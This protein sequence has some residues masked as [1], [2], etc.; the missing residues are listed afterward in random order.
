MPYI[1]LGELELHNRASHP[2]QRQFY[3]EAGI[4]TA[5]FMG[6]RNGEIELGSSNVVQLNMQMEMRTF[7]PEDFSRQLS[8]SA[9]AGDQLPGQ[10][11][12][13]NRPSSSS[14]SLRSFSTGS[15]DSSLI[16]TIPTA[17]SHPHPHLPTDQTT[18]TAAATVTTPSSLQAMSSSII[19]ADPHQ[20]TMQALSEMRNNIQLPSMETENAA[21]TR[22]ILAILTSPT[23]SSS[24]TSHQQNLQNLPNYN[25]YQ[26][27]PNAT[28]FKRYTSSRL[29]AP[30]SSSSAR[31]SLRA[32]SMLKRAITFYRNFNLARREHLLRNRPT[33]TTNQLH[34]MMSERKRREKLNESFV[35]LRSLLPSGTKKDKASVLISTRE[36]LKSLRSQIEELD[37]RNRLLEAQVLPSKEAAGELVN[38]RFNVRI[39]PVPESAS[40]QRIIDLRVSVRGERPIVDVIIHLLEFLKLDRSVSL[41]SIEANTNIT[42]SGS[43]NL[44]NLRLRIEGNGW[45][46]ATFQEAVRRLIADLAQ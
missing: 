20:A 42:E 13:P 39:T 17:P 28:A 2:T 34:H 23:S 35:A 24:S 15:P 40:D 38:E 1:E 46:E 41:M 44:V 45:D 7:F 43:V 6:C 32:Q 21:I 5:V 8:P 25:N 31:A 9:A 10:P 36:Y 19:P 22:A 12:D 29:S 18:T 3:R 30:S 33:T 37:R 11:N 16:F 14:S 27:N 26:R 4:K